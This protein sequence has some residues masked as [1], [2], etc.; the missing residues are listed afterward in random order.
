M[1]REVKWSAIGNMILFYGKTSAKRWVSERIR[2][3]P[4]LSSYYWCLWNCSPCSPGCTFLQF[5]SLPSCSNPGKKCIGNRALQL[6]IR[7]LKLARRN[8]IPSFSCCSF[9]SFL[10]HV[11][12]TPNPLFLERCS[13]SFQLLHPHCMFVVLLGPI[14]FLILHGS[15]HTLICVKNQTTSTRHGAVRLRL[16][17]TGCS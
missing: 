4:F 2:Q 6:V 8:M 3:I 7:R 13:C 11:K 15:S 5:L 16:G 9:V 14:P 10:S 12:P 1:S 17:G